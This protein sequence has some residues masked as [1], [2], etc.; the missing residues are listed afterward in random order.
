MGGKYSAQWWEKI[1]NMNREISAPPD[2]SSIVDHLMAKASGRLP[3]AT[4]VKSST[5]AQPPRSEK[6]LSRAE[7]AVGAARGRHMSAGSRGSG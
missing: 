1:A 6:P 4:N 5:W 2:P 3:P 7:D